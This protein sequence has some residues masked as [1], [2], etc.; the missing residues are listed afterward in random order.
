LVRLNIHG[1]TIEPRLSGSAP[2]GASVLEVVRAR[3]CS[4]ARNQVD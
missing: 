1:P 4:R 2:E 3:Q